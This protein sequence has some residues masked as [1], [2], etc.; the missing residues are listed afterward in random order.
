[1]PRELANLSSSGENDT[2]VPV[3]EGLRMWNMLKEEGEVAT[4]MV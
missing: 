2:R 3:E 4:E 1:M